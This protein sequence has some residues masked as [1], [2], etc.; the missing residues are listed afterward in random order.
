ML[1]RVV[2]GLCAWVLCW[3]LLKLKVGTD[4]TAWAILCSLFSIS[5]F[6]PNKF[7]ALFTHLPCRRS[8]LVFQYSFC[9]RSWQAILL[10]WVKKQFPMNVPPVI[11][12]LFWNCLPY[13][14]HFSSFVCFKAPLFWHSC[15]RIIAS[16]GLNSVIH[17]IH[18]ND[19]AVRLQPVIFSWVMRGHAVVKT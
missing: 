8:P 16:D 11:V 1:N 15:D 19:I 7:I 18:R 9:I 4:A 17:I 5:L 10:S 14:Y 6:F 13:D 12:F 2:K 3:K